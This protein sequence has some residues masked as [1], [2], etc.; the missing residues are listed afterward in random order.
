MRHSII[1]ATMNAV[2]IAAPMEMNDMKASSAMNDMTDAKQAADVSYGSYGKYADHADYGSYPGGV[3][4]A[5]KAMGIY[6]LLAFHVT[7]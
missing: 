3:E 4:E 7:S 1:F 6:V 5:A 2:A